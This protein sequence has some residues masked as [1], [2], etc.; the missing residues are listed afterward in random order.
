MVRA[1]PRLCALAWNRTLTRGN[2]DSLLCTK[3][4]GRVQKCT[5]PCKCLMN[6][7]AWQFPWRPTQHPHL[8]L[9]DCH[10]GYPCP[11]AYQA[12]YF[13]R[14]GH[15]ACPCVPILSGIL[16]KGQAR[17]WHF[18]RC[19]IQGKPPLFGLLHSAFVFLTGT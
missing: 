8:V 7:R 11:N 14:I 15:A 13:L 2:S 18:W 3:K 4:R 16:W 6:S 9:M 12:R 5:W 19:M 17:V 1:V 10:I